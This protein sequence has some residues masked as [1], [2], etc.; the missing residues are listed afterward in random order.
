MQHSAALILIAA[1]HVVAVGYRIGFQMA[2]DQDAANA[3]TVALKILIRENLISL[4][5]VAWPK[6]GVQLPFG[7]LG[8]CYGR[9]RAE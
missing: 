6:F 9:Q 8:R 5:E 4:P 3:W 7:P 2:V 1:H